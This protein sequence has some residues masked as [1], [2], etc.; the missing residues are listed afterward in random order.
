MKNKI[1]QDKEIRLPMYVM[2]KDIKFDKPKKGQ[3]VQ[4]NGVIVLKNK[5]KLNDTD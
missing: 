4:F 1:I 5:G 2:Y 3:Y